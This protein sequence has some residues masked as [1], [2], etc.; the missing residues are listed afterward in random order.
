VVIEPD[1]ATS[2]RRT[3]LGRSA[4]GIAAGA[5]LAISG[6][7]SKSGRPDVHKIPPEAR[8]VD[9]EILNGLL[10]REYKA[11]AAYTAGIPLLESHVQTAAKQF[12][13]QE[14]SHAG[15]LYALIKQAKGVANKAQPSYAF[16]HPRTHKEVVDLLHSLEQSQISGYLEAIPSVSPGSVRAALSS[17]LANDAQ[18]VVI[19]RRALRIE[20]IP[21]AFVTASE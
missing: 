13:S 18:H 17:I 9:V 5:T 20:P 4:V 21:S 8:N 6:C 11:I 12:L 1:A 7:G 15:E 19:L 3:L 2:S 16:G 14:I 10:D